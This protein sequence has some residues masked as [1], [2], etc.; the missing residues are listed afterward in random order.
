MKREVVLT[1]EDRD[2][3][4]KASNWYD[5]KQIYWYQRFQTINLWIKFIRIDCNQINSLG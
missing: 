5:V 4:R 2:G 3:F 1:F